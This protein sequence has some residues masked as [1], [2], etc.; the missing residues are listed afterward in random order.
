M[1]Y[2]RERGPAASRDFK[3]TIAEVAARM[4]VTEEY[5]LSMPQARVVAEAIERDMKNARATIETELLQPAGGFQSLADAPGSMLL[6][7]EANNALTGGARNAGWALLLV[8]TMREHHPEF[9]PSLNRAFA[10]MEATCGS[11]N[12]P[13][14]TDRTQ[15]AQWG[16]WRGIAPLSAAIWSWQ[17]GVTRKDQL[18]ERLFS[19]FETRE[20]VKKVLQYA[21]WFRQFG[22]TFGAR[23]GKAP[24]LPESEAV[25]YQ[26]DLP[27]LRPV[28]PALVPAEMEAATRYRAATLKAGY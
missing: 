28:L 14:V 1:A 18:E 26:V 25:V 24:L 23:N 2:F 8:A 13:S 16:E 3:A 11:R 19:A 21:K 27:A 17:F 10:V 20:G 12:W 22:T 4:G 5:V 6:R 7:Q 9:A 15:K